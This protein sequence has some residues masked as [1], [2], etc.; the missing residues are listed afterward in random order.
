MTVPLLPPARH[1]FTCH[2]GPDGDAC[3]AECYYAGWWVCY[4]CG[5]IYATPKNKE[6]GRDFWDW[7]RMLPDFDKIAATRA[8][9][10]LE[11]D[12][13]RTEEDRSV[14]PS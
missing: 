1:Y 2:G 3:G 11:D 10:D 9:E 12:Q 4:R 5:M 7:S 6:E 13:Q 14:P 8:Q